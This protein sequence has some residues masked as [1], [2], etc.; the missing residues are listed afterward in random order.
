MNVALRTPGMTREQFFD[1]VQHQQERYEF[2]GSKPVPMVRVTANHSR[3]AQNIYAAL[4]SRLW[5][6]AWEVF[7]PDSGVATVGAAVRCPDALITRT[8]PAG[9]DLLVP[10]PV[11]MF[12]VLSPS[13]GQVDRIVKV[14]EYA[15]VPSILCYVILEYA[16]PGLTVFERAEAGQPWTVA[17]LLPGDTLALP[18]VGIEVPVA[19]FYERVDLPGA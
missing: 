10:D 9:A 19:E 14:R 11:I 12:E 3:I 6:S 13:S 7:G 16:G 17:T 5:D 2:D 4:R 1:W 18:E 15:A 8:K